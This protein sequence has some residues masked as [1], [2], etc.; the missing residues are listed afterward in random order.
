[1]AMNEK[2]IKKVKQ[3]TEYL[4]MDKHTIYK[5]AHTGLIP[6][7]KITGQCWFKKVAIDKWISEG[8]FKRVRKNLNSYSKEEK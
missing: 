4:Q 5:L 8:S 6:S 2:T 3:V 7:L 1:M